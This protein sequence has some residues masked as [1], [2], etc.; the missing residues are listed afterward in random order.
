MVW[1]VS[2]AKMFER[3]Q[4]Q[5]FYKTKLANARAKDAARQQAYRLSKLQSI[6]GWRGNVVDQVLSKE[7]ILALERGWSISPDRVIQAA[8][9]RFDRQLAI[10]RA[11]RIMD[12]AIKPSDYGDDL[13]AFHCLEYDGGVDKDEIARAHDEV[14]TAIKTFFGMEDLIARL[15]TANRLI[16]QRALTFVHSDTTV[17]AVPDVIAFF[18]SAPPTIIDWKVHS[19]GWRDAWLQLAVYAAALTRCNPHKDFP[20]ATDGY[21]ETDIEL[22]EVQLL[23]GTI[24][25]HDLEGRDIAEADAYIALSAG[26]HGTGRRRV[27]R[28]GCGTRPKNLSGDALSR[29][30]RALPISFPLLGESSMMDIETNIFPVSNI[31][32]LGYSYDTYRVRNLRRDQDEYFQNRDG[33]VRTLS[34]R[35]G[36]P[37][38]A[39]ERAGE[40]F[41]VIPSDARGVPDRVSLVRTNVYLEKVASGTQLDFTARN[42]ENDAICLRIVQFMLQAPLWGNVRLWQPGSGSPFFEK[43][44]AEELGG[45]GRYCGFAVRAV[46]APSERIGLCVDI[47]SKY[48]RTDSIPV[49]LD[50]SE[51][52]RFKGRRCIYRYGHQWYEIRIETMS[53]LNVS[54]EEIQ[55][56]TGRVSLLD[57]MVDQCRKPIP[58]ELAALPHNATVLRYRNNRGEE[59]TVAAGLC[60][61]VCDN[62]QEITRRLHERAIIPPAIRRDLTARNVAQYLTTLRFK[63]T[64]LR[65]DT[66]PE[67]IGQQVFPIPDLEFGNG[68]T[69]SVR[70]TQGANQVGLDNFGQRRIDLLRREEVG[71]YVKEPFRRQYLILPQSVAES[72]G[73]QFLRDLAQVVDELYPEGAGYE[74]EI[75]TYRDRGPRTY[76]DQGKAVLEALE[77]QILDPAYA[78]VMVHRTTNRKIREHDALAAMVIRGLRKKHIYAAVNHSEMGERCYV[79]VSGRDGTPRYEIR[80]R[81]RGRFFGYLRNVALNKILLTNNFW[82]FILASPLNADVTIGIDVK[83]QTAGFTVIGKRGAF[84]QTECHTSQ[85]KEKLLKP[86]VLTHLTELLRDEC[87]RLGRPLRSIAIHRDGRCWQS[88]IDGATTAMRMLKN[89]GVV[90]E[91]GDLTILEISKTAPARLRLFEVHR[92]HTS[93]P[94]VENPQVGTHALING[95][96]GFLCSTGR[97]FPHKGSVQ[98]LHVRCVLEG[99]P[100]RDAL[101]DIYALTT[102]AWTRPEDCSR[103]PITLKLT[104]RWL[105]EEA[106]EFDEDT[107]RY[108]VEADGDE[109]PERRAVA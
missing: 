58:A 1:S 60:Y 12:P 69:L 16:A 15:R 82:P 77:H 47:R 49:H 61:P 33:L 40:P 18:A 54:E 65:V 91:D 99:M 70:G 3:C 6:S 45:I 56:Q 73:T 104:D 55:T 64:T 78:M 28:K 42:P 72:W 25:V 79:M 26:E 48:V 67:R 105:G 22:L 68:C 27:E 88:E 2:T 39:V 108:I 20:V 97:A 24:R 17:R 109:K 38:E 9:A 13:A 103:Y 44:P 35:L 90:A 100:F 5:W 43:K 11:H 98:P 14:V 53:D 51:F 66:E 32:E 59:R 36:A 10:A 8:L 63:N 101:E 29:S 74:P 96:E 46:I 107:L 87:R 92:T 106:S 23:T 19:F 85:Q 102:L 52:R 76:R 89:E 57:Y 84:V 41:L 80:R 94:H 75:V 83:N 4:R 50:R 34:F 71:F 81:D 21:M 93:R 31:E 30:M 7:V 62:Q 95:V 37:V 86:Q